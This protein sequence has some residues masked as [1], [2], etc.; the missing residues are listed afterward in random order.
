MSL[1]AMFLPKGWLWKRRLV[2]YYA[3]LDL[4]VQSD[5]MAMVAWQ[6]GNQLETRRKIGLARRP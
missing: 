6:S 4:F 2:R 5:Q 1:L 3:D